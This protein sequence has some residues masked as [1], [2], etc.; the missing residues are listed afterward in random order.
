MAGVKGRSGGARPG[1]GRKP[2]KPA[3]TGLADPLDFLKA[4]WL[5]EVEANVAQV[6]AATAALPFMHK[7]LGEGGKAKDDAE[8]AQ[9]EAAGG[10][11]GRRGMPRLAAADGK[12]VK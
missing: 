3:A 7:K 1:A 10:K 2:K 4:V 12:A 11:F 5:G 8:A 9:K 6:R